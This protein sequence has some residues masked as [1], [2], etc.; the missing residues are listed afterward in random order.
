[1]PGVARG[2]ARWAAYAL[3]TLVLLL[4][5]GISLTVGWRPVFGPK[6]RALTDRHFESTP[7]RLQRGE[8]LV[9]NVSLCFGCHTPFDAKGRDVPLFTAAKGS[10]QTLAD[11]DGFKVVAPNITPDPDTG[12][13]R[14]TDDE[15]ARAIR[16]GIGRDGRALFP[17]M[18]Y[19]NFRNMSD[20]DLA[21]IIVYL[22]AQKPVRN[23]P[24]KTKLPFP[25]S[26]LINT[27]PQPVNAPVPAP[28]GSN[29][30]A[31]GKYLAGAVGDCN[32]C[33]TP[34]DNHGQAIPHMDLAGGNLFPE[35]GV[36]VASANLTPDPS[37]IAYYDEATFI[38]VM[39]TGH[40]RGRKLN[41]MMPW[42]AFKN[43]TDADL[44]A[45]YAYLRTLPPVRHRIDNTETATLCPI[46]GQKHG[47]GNK[48]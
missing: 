29:A 23:V 41:V 6:K 8:Y 7:A 1:M 3:I 37:G 4:V 45:I 16:E 9:E 19:G 14:W 21:S 47:L 12:I 20:D 17:M 26:R 31:Y 18:P 10:G 2:V 39:R 42:W 22:R 40:V 25:V 36:T 15:L 32:G 24:G 34:R 46:D 5:V 11:K 35:S 43:M 27:A 48:N 13:G 44:K 33:H 30:V 28:D 38:E